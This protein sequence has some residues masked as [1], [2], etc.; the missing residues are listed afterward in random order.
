MARTDG[1]WEVGSDGTYIRTPNDGYNVLINGTNRYLNFNT[2]VGSTGY[3]I[4]D[5]AGVMEFK[6]SGGAWTPLGGGGGGA[7]TSVFG[8]TGA[9]M[10]QASDY[11]AFYV[12]DAGGSTIQPANQT[13]VGLTIHQTTLGGLS[14]HLLDFKDQFGNIT[15]FFDNIGSTLHVSQLEASIIAGTNNF[16]RIDVDNYQLERFTGS[17]VP[18]IKW[19]SGFIYG[20][21]G[22]TVIA[23]FNDSDGL[24]NPIFH[25]PNFQTDKI[26]ST[27]GQVILDVVDGLINHP[28]DGTVVIDLGG[29]L[30]Y[31]NTGSIVAAFNNVSTTF[32]SLFTAGQF[33]TDLIYSNDTT[34]PSISLDWDAISTEGDVGAL[35]EDDDSTVAHL[36]WGSPSGISI[37]NVKNYGKEDTAGTGLEPI[38]A[39]D[40]QQNLNDTF[41]GTTLIPEDDI[42]GHYEIKIAVTVQSGALAGT[43]DV[44]VNYVNNGNGYITNFMTALDVTSGGVAYSGVYSF[45][46]S[47]DALPIGYQTVFTGSNAG[48][49]YDI[50]VTITR[51]RRG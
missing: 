43:L 49:L 22:S 40:Y 16:Q 4:R 47:K 18:V 10:A 5:N 8:R 32:D 19:D 2:L 1:I 28:A 11:S 46:G 25:A 35:L 20:Y 45:T 6:N 7:V 41:D 14:A 30:I 29:G 12:L 39:S 44:F 15:A 36:Q 34:N 50:D 17:Y 33:A 51:S 42:G 13:T 26:W 9:V 37:S 38:I 3:G 24:G 31:N 21:D 23:T 27:G 48:L